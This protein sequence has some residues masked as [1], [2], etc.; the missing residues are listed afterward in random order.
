MDRPNV[1]GSG[2]PD[3]RAEVPTFGEMIERSLA[4][5]ERRR[6][7]SHTALRMEFGLD[8]T[9]FTALRDELVDV[10]G[11][12]D[13]DG[14]V[15]AVRNGRSA[16]APAMHD[17][18]V[19]APAPLAAGGALVSVLLC[20]LAETPALTAL[21]A[22]ARS[23]VATRFAAIC[24]EVAGRQRGHVQPWVADSIAIFFGHPGAEDDD[25]VRAV[26]CG[27]EILRAVGAARGAIERE[28]G[29]HV[30]P[31]LAIAT[32]PAA[33]SADSFGDTPRLAG[34]VQA[35]GA[36]DAV[37]V[38]DATRELTSEH[39]AFAPGTGDLFE[40]RGPHDA[41]APVHRAPAPLVGRTGER[42]LLRALAE[43]AADGAR[44]AVLVR[45][46]AG[47]GKTRLIATL[48]AGAGEELG[49]TVLQCTAS[50]YHRGSPLHP[51][52]AG[53]R[54]HWEL[55]G[56]DASARLGQRATGL[57]GR[58]RAVALLA[59][60]LGVALP[61]G[62]A[63]LPEMSAR[64]RRRETLA[65][66]A[67]A[68]T[69]EASRAPLLL[70]VED[71][72]WADPTTLE[73]IG[74]L[75]D[76]PRELALMLALTARSEYVPPPGT[77]L[78]RIELGRLD[79][80][81]SRRLAE[82]VAPEN[83]LADGV[84][85]DLALRGNG[86]PLLVEELTRTILAT[87]HAEPAGP[88]TL[89]G[90]L[91]ARLDRDTSARAVAQL[92]ATIGREF[93]VALLEAVGGIERSALEWGLE[94]L[95]QE[96]VVVPTGPGSYAFRHTLLQEAARSSLGKEVLREHNLR[97][98]RALKESFPHVAAAEPER[99]ARHLEYG[100]S[101]PASVRRWRQA[102]LQALHRHAL[103]EATAHFERGL[104][105]TART[106]DGDERRGTELSLRVLAGLAIAEQHGWDHPA[107]TTHYARAE[108]L[109]RQVAGAPMLVRSMLGL[110][111]YELVTSRL[112]EALAL[113][114][115]Q[116][117]VA[118]RARDRELLLESECEAGAAL[119][120]LGRHRDA[121][122][123]FAR[124]IELYDPAG[125]DEHVLRYGRNPAAV[126]LANRGLALACRGDRTG[127]RD[128][129]GQAAAVLREHRHS[130][131]EA[132]IQCA[133]AGA[134]LVCG[135][136]DV[137]RR[138]AS[139]ALRIAA[140]EGF[141][142]WLAHASVL[143]GWA[144]VHAGEH[145]EGL[146]ECRRGVAQWASKGIVVLRPFLHGLLADALRAAGDLDHGIV[147]VDQALTGCVR[148]ERWCE[149]EL[150][151]IRAELLLACGVR[152][153]ALRAA[154]MAV[155]LSRR[156]GAA[157]WERRAESTLRRV[158]GAAPVA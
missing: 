107:A 47:V 140:E 144:R 31:R 93:D 101:L 97:I 141:P 28:L 40:L 36:P 3:Y 95:V 67:A 145:E 110:T 80:D 21:D 142:E 82:A 94:R 42:A 129:I 44:A 11:V 14:R 24:G 96:E 54:R 2:T 84:A 108:Q 27:W 59:D 122:P 45:G 126:A 146:E 34:R 37:T 133:A 74:T 105:L 91:M 155:A 13:D 55:D 46:E 30:S 102:G 148:G 50:P 119:L 9:T 18:A 25:A 87:Q 111:T 86:S 65:V 22:G 12:A 64:R 112:E 57:P 71:L 76:G 56:A 52:L 61:E 72:H 29:L 135:E 89:Y 79:P 120:Y 43:R 134:A 150:H 137:V 116:V 32:G 136:R 139:V 125:H 115:E 58:E 60:Q 6:R 33:V 19:P 16:P 124:A 98:A 10:L 83:A 157:G 92:A 149:P 121:L 109:R 81:E 20:D 123:R 151:R 73:L 4:L 7:V 17:A 143:H 77:T 63:P 38:D 69:A 130:Y 8:D 100:G 103:R 128:A 138:E 49:M 66:L 158:S 51:L 99:V 106:P 131:T 75:L 15:L 85:A 114:R 152:P 132:W 48:A 5:L 70:V 23:A 62:V 41:G 156:S 78:Q 127:A 1:E 113:A 117:K 88:A 153:G 35:A 104:Q 147:A 26:R 53:L 39:F 90:C 118:E 154:Q 68:L